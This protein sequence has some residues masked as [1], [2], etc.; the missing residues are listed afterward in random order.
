[1]DYDAKLKF[2]NAGIYVDW[3]PGDSSFRLSAGALVGSRKLEG[4]G[5]ASNGVVVING[6]A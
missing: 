3:F 5:Q 4:T 6:T 2:A 1:M